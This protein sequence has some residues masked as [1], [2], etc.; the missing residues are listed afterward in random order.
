MR[1]F[2]HVFILPVSRNMEFLEDRLQAIGLIFHNIGGELQSIGEGFKNKK[3]GLLKRL[4][5]P[6][7]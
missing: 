1:K 5:G 4:Y 3:K 2:P 7:S 6:S